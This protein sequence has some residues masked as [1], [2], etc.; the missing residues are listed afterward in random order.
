[1]QGQGEVLRST[2]NMLFA[3]GL[4]SADGVPALRVSGIFKM[5]PVIG[6]GTAKDP[7]GLFAARN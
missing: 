6:D 2:R 4:V 1:M 5:G 7:F 3:Q